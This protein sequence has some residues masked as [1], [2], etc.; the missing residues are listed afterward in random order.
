MAISVVVR[1]RPSQ[2][3][4]VLPTRRFKLPV[5]G[6]LVLFMGLVGVHSAGWMSTSLQLSLGEG[7]RACLMVGVT[8]LGMKTSLGGLART[9]W[10]PTVLMLATSLWIALFV[11]GAIEVAMQL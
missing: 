8:A 7:S 2:T 9:G 11:L 6:F 5:P 4:A 3:A 1:K 10:R